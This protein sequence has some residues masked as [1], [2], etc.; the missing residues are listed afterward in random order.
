MKKWIH[1]HSLVLSLLFVLAVM[2]MI[3]CFSAQSGEE[4]GAMSGRFTT[5][6]LHIFVPDFDNM[7]AQAQTQLRDTVGLVIRKLAHF[8][9]YALLGFAL[10]LHI[11]QVQ[12]RISVRLSWLWAWGV[13]TLYAASDE[14]HQGF[15]A[16]RG[17]SVMDVMID[18]AGVIAGVLLLVWL[19]R[20]ATK[21]KIPQKG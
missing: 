2:V 1:K 4:S 12:K 7:S 3:F 15:V 9:E 6:M 10:L 18:S 21:N 13:G 5:W 8:S 20:C 17:P 14:F 19:L 11:S 16:D